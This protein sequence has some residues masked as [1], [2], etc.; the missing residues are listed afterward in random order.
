METF[1]EKLR[2]LKPVLVGLLAA[3]AVVLVVQN[4]EAV[5]TQVLFWSVEMPRFAMLAT[6]YLL[7]AATGWILHW[8]ARRPE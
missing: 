2:R 1:L 5:Q 8:Q 7:G 4:Q 6:V 3:V